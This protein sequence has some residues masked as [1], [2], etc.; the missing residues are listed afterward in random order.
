[1]WRDVGSAI[2]I[3]VAL[4]WLT[5]AFWALATSLKITPNILLPVPYWL[6]IPIA[7]D[8]YIEVLSG[9]RTVSAT[10]AVANSA[11]VAVLTTFATV[12]ICTLTAYPLAR[13]E[14][15][16]RNL[17]FGIIVGSMMVPGVITIVPLYLLM[18]KLGWLN[19]YQALIVPSIASAFGVFL[20][21]QFFL[22]LP[23]ELEDAARIDGANSWTILTGLL[24]PLS[25]PAL[26]ALA[27][28][29]FQAT[30]NDFTWPLIVMTKQDRL[31]LP[32]A[33][34]LI[35]GDYA[36][37]SFGPIMAGAVISAIPLLVVFI[38]ANRQIIE[39]VQFSGLKM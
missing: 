38:V 1:I 25:K 24:L 37:D 35:R 9:T 22:S 19:S 31:T 6:P 5:P 26:G 30:W 15:P 4:L 33:L 2:F 36:N 14:F 27:L 16:G 13:M 32:V 23:V 17:V 18:V 7:L 12:F 28:F 8:Q 20:L 39:G 29:T 11:I 21:R 34:S 3:V 10:V